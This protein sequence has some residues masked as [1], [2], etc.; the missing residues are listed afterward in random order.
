MLLMNKDIDWKRF[1]VPRDGLIDLSDHGFLSDPDEEWG[2]YLNPKLV[3]F[4]RLDDKRCVV[5]L[6]EPGIGKSW[7][8][9]KESSRVQGSLEAGAK[10]LRRDLRSYGDP[11]DEEPNAWRSR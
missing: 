2:K 7:A 8:L 1:W 5:L 4:D 9:D 3:T 10:L 11:S 6:G